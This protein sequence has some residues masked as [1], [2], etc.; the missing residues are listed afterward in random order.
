MTSSPGGGQQRMSVQQALRAANS[1]AREG[2]LVQAEGLLRQVLQQRPNDAEVLHQ[3]AIV[4]HQSGN[5]P[6]AAALIERAI[7]INPNVYL[8][9][10]NVGEMRRRLGQPR[11]A[12]EHGRRAVELNAGAA[13]PHNNLG[14]AY[15]DVGDFEQA[16]KCYDA[17]IA[18]RPRFPEA[19]SNRGNVLRQLKRLDEA[20]ADYRRAL[21]I[22]PNYAEAW[23]NLG[24]VLRDLERPAEAEQA[25]RRSISLN[26]K[27]LE[28]ANNLVLALKDQEKFDEALSAANAALKLNPKNPDALTYS[29]AI[30]LE[31]RQVPAAFDLLRQAQA[32]APNRPETVNI[33]GRAH[34]EA[35][36]AE[37]AIEIYRRAIALKGDVADPY[38]NMGNAFREIGRFDEAIEA[39]GTALKINPMSSGTYL[40]LSDVKKFRSNDDADVVAM[41]RLLG[42]AKTDDRRM[43]LSYALGKAYDDLRRYDEA[44]P[45]Y[46][47]ANALKRKS[48]AYDERAVLGQFERL[49][50]IMT[51]ETIAGLAGN[52]AVSERPIFVLGMPRSGTTL[53]EQI[54]ASHSAVNGLG[55]LR[56]MSEVSAEVRGLDGRVATYP[57]YVPLLGG[58][59]FERLGRNYLA[60]TEKRAGG[61]ARA[62]DKM[63]SNF[64]FLGLI[65]LILPNAKIVHLVRDPVD[66][67]LSCFTKLFAGEQSQTYDLAELG[68]FYRHYHGL[69]AHWRKVLPPGS[70]LDVRY[71]DVVADIEGEARRIVEYCRLP[72]E[73]SVVDFHRNERPI[74]TASSTQVRQPI[75]T[76][77]VQRWRKYE[78]H[79][80]PLLQELGDLVP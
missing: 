66:T 25:Y 53:V 34:F 7:G 40:N 20:E 76:S 37:K 8:Y 29:A 60:R 77:S 31:K 3:L 2:K 19:I 45:L 16:L 59:E 75:Y 30:L 33:L 28:A 63:P 47:A 49:Q 80:G 21:T 9:H 58:A 12:I 57:E 38:N 36:D 11:Q 61:A 65:H 14:I 32:L 4:V 22:L 18:A 41:E 73:P 27:Y 35:G 10:A 54:I 23:N 44:F 6:L 78:R 13:E 48:I 26:G 50:R 70:F 67:C 62:T 17:A 1:L 24:T 71:E 43:H 42:E 55:E 68:R 15:F 72:W 52:G 74:K 56:D 39:F 5:T 69:M 64:L 46:L 51:R 79:L